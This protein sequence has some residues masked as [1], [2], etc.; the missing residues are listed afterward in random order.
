MRTAAH[1][2][3]HSQ[4]RSISHCATVYVKESFSPPLTLLLISKRWPDVPRPLPC[5]PHLR[6]LTVGQ[7]SEQSFAVIT[8]KKSNKTHQCY[9]I[10][11]KCCA[12]NRLHSVYRRETVEIPR[13]VSLFSSYGMW[14]FILH[15]LS[16]MSPQR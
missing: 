14:G 5:R 16:F 6:R 1:R 13:W 3:Q 11:S 15:T 4:F 7:G 9:S 10:C 2:V 12:S 8:F